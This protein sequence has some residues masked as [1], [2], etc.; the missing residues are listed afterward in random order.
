[1]MLNK[2]LL[3]SAAIAGLAL[4]T[5]TQQLNNNKSKVSAD[6][7]AKVSTAAAV[8]TKDVN[9]AVSSMNSVKSL[10]LSAT[11]ADSDA[12]VQNLSNDQS[13]S[14]NDDS[15]ASSSSAQVQPVST[16]TTTASGDIQWLISRES[17]G[18]VNARNGSMYGLG[19]LSE[20]AYA[21]YAPGQNYEGNY[22]VQ[23]QAMQGYIAD[24]YGS[25]SNAIAHFQSN[26]WY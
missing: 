4:T 12:T 13:S 16:Q 1:M 14:S 18:N 22:D 7:T 25:V 23:L 26:G 8:N 5:A 21:T 15:Q 24:R 11:N 19:Q 9:S 10:Q 6:K 17:G 20:A 2:V 3:T